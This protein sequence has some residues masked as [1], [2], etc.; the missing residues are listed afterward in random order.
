MSEEL[1]RAVAQPIV[2]ARAHMRITASAG[3]ILATPGGDPELLLRDADTALY[4]AKRQGRNRHVVFDSKLHD[5][6]V[7]R[8]ELETALLEAIADDQ[9]AVH[10]QPI[11]HLGSARIVG[12]EALARWTHPELGAMD[13]TDFITVA[14][15]IGIVHEVDTWV[16]RHAAAHAADWHRCFG[17]SVAVNLSTQTLSLP[18]LA[19]SVIRTLDRHG[20]PPAAIGI[21]VTETSYAQA[22]QTTIDALQTLRLRGVRVSIDD[23]GTGYSSI[24][25]VRRF[26]VDTIKIDRTLIDAIPESTRDLAIVRAISDLAHA[27][28]LTLT[29]EGVAR[30]EQHGALYAL[31]C[32]T[33]QGFLYGRPATA[34]EL[35][36]E[37]AR[38]RLSIDEPRD[39]ARNGSS[40]KSS[41]VR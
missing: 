30:T 37:F 9:L 11:V 12:V 16:L 17:I 4:E 27:L 18:D 14:E 15:D 41:R 6:V 19:Q 26:P 39:V 8:V 24:D 35:Q 7:R 5:H 33:A 25:R 34:A 38:S 28:D 36:G 40:R 20:T 31:G 2:M 23:F 29:A 21:E 32:D 10:Y 3:A 13:P 22:P 1:R